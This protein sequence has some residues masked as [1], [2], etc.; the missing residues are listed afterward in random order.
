[1]LSVLLQGVAM[2][3]SCQQAY[4]QGQRRGPA[5]ACLRLLWHVSVIRL[6]EQRRRPTVLWPF[7]DNLLCHN[8]AHSREAVSLA[9]LNGLV[10]L[11]L[12]M[13]PSCLLACMQS[14]TGAS[15]ACADLLIRHMAAED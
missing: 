15:T 7:L 1:M 14:R 11:L 13:L 2:F 10:G 5:A 4:E 9:H 12:V 8:A 3:H 6:K